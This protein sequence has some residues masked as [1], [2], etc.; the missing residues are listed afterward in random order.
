[1]LSSP[2]R[3]NALTFAPFGELLLRGVKTKLS[4]MGVRLLFR[5]FPLPAGMHSD[6][7]TQPHIQSIDKTDYI[8]CTPT[9]L[10]FKFKAFPFSFVVHARVCTF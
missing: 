2:L 10:I 4:R 1:M 8:K 9:K 3:H 7:E 6:D 5:L